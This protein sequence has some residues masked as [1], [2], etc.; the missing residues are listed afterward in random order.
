MESCYRG[1]V[2]SSFS[3]KVCLCPVEVD[4]A[5]HQASANGLE[6]FRPPSKEIGGSATLKH[7]GYKESFCRGYHMA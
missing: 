6:S 3:A 4:R 2:T 1:T 5:P 7:K